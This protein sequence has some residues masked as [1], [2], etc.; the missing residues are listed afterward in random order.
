M[1]HRAGNASREVLITGGADFLGAHLGAQLLATSDACVSLVDDLVAPGALQNVEWLKSQAGEDRL[2]LVRGRTRNTLRLA[3]AASR[4]DEIYL[5]SGNRDS[6]DGAMDAVWIV[7]EAARR[8]GRNPAL[9]CASATGSISGLSQA[10]AGGSARE[11]SSTSRFVQD[12]ARRHQLAAVTL[13]MDTVTGPRQFDEAL[14]WVARAE[15][16]ILGGR[17][18]HIAGD[19]SE[20]HDVLH[21]SDAVQALLAARAYI[22]K[23][24]G[25]GYCLRGGQAHQVNIGEMVQLIER[26]CH[27][28]AQVDAPWRKH[29]ASPLAPLADPTFL[30]DTAWMPR[31]SIEET[32]REIAAFW[33]A[34]RNLIAA[35]PQSAR[36]SHES[37]APQRAASG[38]AA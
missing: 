13:Q 3:D 37:T 32:V 35:T 27:R 17:R 8:S 28:H 14:D 4:A 12:F 10:F 18:C 34:N 15:Y 23:I 6:V 33:H 9:I 2:N 30:V 5:L 38:K 11:F 25:K 21:V 29:S 16:A 24:T 1:L 31:R 7:L 26:V 22:G 36:I 19:V 20:T